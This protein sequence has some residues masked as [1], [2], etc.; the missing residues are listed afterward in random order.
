MGLLIHIGGDMNLDKK[1]CIINW[2]LVALISLACLTG[3]T[4]GIWAQE[5]PVELLEISPVPSIEP[6]GTIV[7]LVFDGKGRIDRLDGEEIV[8]GDRLRRLTGSALFYT[9]LGK[10]SNRDLFHQ[11][12]L[13]GYLKNKHN[14]ITAVYKLK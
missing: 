14:E 8:V 10:V 13:V 5:Q 12:D 3:T 2:C 9:K 4:P 11:G 1:K 7:P 6:E